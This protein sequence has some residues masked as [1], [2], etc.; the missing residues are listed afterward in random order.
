MKRY[1]K[2]TTEKLWYERVMC[3]VKME[4]ALYKASKNNAHVNIRL[5]KRFR[6]R[7]DLIDAELKKR[8]VL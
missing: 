1:A 8:D 7:R 3:S 6:D 4:D 2:M 5:V